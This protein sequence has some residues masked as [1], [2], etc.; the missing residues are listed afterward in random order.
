MNNPRPADRIATRYVQKFYLIEAPA[1]FPV[2][3][4]GYGRQDSTYTT[5][6]I[7]QVLFNT[8]MIPIF[9]RYMQEKS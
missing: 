6:I 9:V 2:E 3:I 7:V 1:S 8:C 4:C 5:P